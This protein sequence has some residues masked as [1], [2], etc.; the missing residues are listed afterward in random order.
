M[1][2][3]SDEF[4]HSAESGKE[5]EEEEGGEGEEG[6]RSPSLRNSVS[7]PSRNQEMGCPHQSSSSKKV[8]CYCCWF[9]PAALQT[10][11]PL[12]SQRGR[13]RVYL[14]TTTCSAA[15]TLRSAPQAAACSA[16]NVVRV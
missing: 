12:W 1:D 15:E 16:V 13:P 3:D 4:E 11:A 14:G 5:E 8:S 10:R 2:Q 6:L 9:C 7:V